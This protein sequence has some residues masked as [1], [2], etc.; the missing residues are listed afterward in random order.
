MGTS[1]PPIPSCPSPAPRNP[2]AAHSRRT[3]PSPHSI[4]GGRTQLP[5]SG[6]CSRTMLLG[7]ALPHTSPPQDDPSQPPHCCPSIFQS[8]S[9]EW[10][11]PRAALG[12]PGTP[13]LQSMRW[14]EPLVFQRPSCYLHP[15]SSTPHQ[16]PTRGMRDLHWQLEAQ[17]CSLRS[18]RHRVLILTLP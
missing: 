16:P 10:P 8:P 17:C 2:A 18:G 5:L 7:E 14:M 11:C 12:A 9:P 13:M 15:Q 3:Q 1:P 4:S 6:A